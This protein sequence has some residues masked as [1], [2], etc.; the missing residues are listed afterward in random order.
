[1][2]ITIKVGTL[3]YV[4]HNFSQKVK[5]KTKYKGVFNI[6]PTMNAQKN[7]FVEINGGQSVNECGGICRRKGRPTTPLINPRTQFRESCFFDRL[8]Q[9]IIK[10]I[11]VQQVRSIT[12][13]THLI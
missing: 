1:M 3:T 10:K 8:S 2:S 7:L 6:I 12:I 9:I 13:I 11:C 4:S 5:R